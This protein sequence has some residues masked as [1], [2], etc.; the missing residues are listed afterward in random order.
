V[1]RSLPASG[2]SSIQPISKHQEKQ[3]IVNCVLHF[4]PAD[5][6]E[7]T[8]KFKKS[9]KADKSAG[10]FSLFPKDFCNFADIINNLLH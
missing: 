4:S 8:E 2:R 1:V 5:L 3:S 10:C 9:V 7:L 6:S